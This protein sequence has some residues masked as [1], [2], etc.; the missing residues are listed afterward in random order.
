MTLNIFLFFDD[1]VV[2]FLWS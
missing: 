2:L 1:L